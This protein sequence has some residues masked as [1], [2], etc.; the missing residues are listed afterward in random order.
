[1][2]FEDDLR[3]TVEDVRREHQRERG[4]RAAFDAQWQ[5]VRQDIVEPVLNDAVPL[6]RAVG[7]AARKDHKNGSVA[8][9]F[10]IRDDV[11][12]EEIWTRSLRFMPDVKSRVVVVKSQS[13][14]RINA[15]ELDRDKVESLVKDFVREAEQA[16]LAAE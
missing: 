1:M 6:I 16:A 10:G 8:L 15:E 11:E 3:A 13:E 9:E 5:K 2:P 4:E 12:I 14:K 7:R